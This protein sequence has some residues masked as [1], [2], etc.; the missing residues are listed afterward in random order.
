MQL[1][2]G[3]RR[4]LRRTKKESKTGEDSSN[5]TAQVGPGVRGR[6]KSKKRKNGFYLDLTDLIWIEIGVKNFFQ[7]ISSLAL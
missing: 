2:N 3:L 4:P 1:P 5:H 7:G 6:K